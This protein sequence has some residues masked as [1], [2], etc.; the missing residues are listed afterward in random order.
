WSLYV[1]DEWRMRDD[2]ALTQGL[3]YTNNEFYGGH[4]APRIYGVWNA[5]ENLTVK[6][7]ISTGYKT[8]EHRSI[9][10][11]YAYTSGGAG[12]A[13]N[14]PPSCAV[15]LGNPDLKPEKTLNFELAAVYEADTFT[16]SAT[17]FHTKFEDKLQQRSLGRDTNGDGILDE[18]DYW[19]DGPQYVGSDGQLYYRRIIQN[20]NVDERS[21]EH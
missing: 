21:E 18:Y 17:A 10:P 3:R 8:P 9:M 13:S 12:C 11:G 5:T 6:G 20:F 19:T 7:G 16:V 1:E 15:I 4:I 14:T 2:F